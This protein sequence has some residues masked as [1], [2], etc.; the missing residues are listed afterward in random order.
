MRVISIAAAVIGLAVIVALIVH[1]GAAPITR[2]LAAVGP[3]GFAAVCSIHLLL[4]AVM[5]IAWWLLMPATNPWTAIWARL[6]RDSA[7][8]V[9][10]LSQLGGYVVG[11]RTLAVA[12]VPASAAAASTIVD[13]TLEFFAQLAFV[14]IGLLWLLHLEPRLQA[15]WL[16][17]LGLGVALGLAVGCVV[18]QRRGFGM[19]DRLAGGIARGWAQRTAAGAAALH[20]TIAEIYDRS[21]GVWAS[22]G[23]H[24]VCWIASAA[25]VWLALGW[26]G[27][28]RGFGVVL[29]IESLLY[30]A[31]SVAFAVPNAV[32][33]QEVAYLVLGTRFGL[34]PEIA[35]ALSLL[36]RARDFAIG[37]PV[38]GVY[39]IV[40]SGRLSRFVAPVGRRLLIKTAKR[41]PG[42]DDRGSPLPAL[43]E[44]ARPTRIVLED[45]QGDIT[46]QAKSATLPLKLQ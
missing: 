21:S 36:K 35:L 9:L 3:A 29:V 41:N 11:A 13:V 4:I 22:F 23:L 39:Q 24:L 17:T 25:E 18:A 33:V 16:D 45:H 15:A 19:L 28:A 1:F 14:A 12:G 26:M 5:G 40:E 27:A 44:K 46:M 31:R 34:P 43:E 6:V 32:G 38:L 37:L 10:P 8:E 42:R 20:C 2:S 30:A 7:S